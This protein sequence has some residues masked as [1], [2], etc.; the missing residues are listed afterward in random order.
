MRQITHLMVA[1]AATVF[2]LPASAAPISFSTTL[3]PEVMGA[4]GSGSARV[5]FDDV[6]LTMFVEAEFEGLSGTTTVAHIHCCTVVPGAGTIGVA[7]YPGTFPGFPV[8]VTAGSYSNTFDMSLATSYTAGFV[9]TFGGGTVPGAFAAVIAGLDAGRG[10]FNVHST[11]FG[12]GEIRGFL[13]RVP[14]PGA[15]A[16]IGLGLVLVAFATR[17][18]RKD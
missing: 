10:Y 15:L 6:A 8:G 5:V 11:A 12:G 18:R 16:L 7:T 1:L 13:V 4:T 14:E 9:T 17:R 3:G 2:G